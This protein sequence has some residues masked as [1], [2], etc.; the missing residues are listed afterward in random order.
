MLDRDGSLDL[1]RSLGCFSPAWALFSFLTCSHLT[2]GWTGSSVF[3][4]GAT[5]LPAR[6]SIDPS[7]TASSGSSGVVMLN[8]SS[9]RERMVEAQIARRGIRD[10]HVLQAMRRVPREAFV[11]PGFDEFA[12]ED[13]PLP[14]GEDQTIS[15]PYIVA[16]MIEA[17]E[18][19]PGE[20]V[21]E[22]GAGSGYSAAV[23][24]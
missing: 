18:V 20:R 23:L 21:L 10:R 11:E 17:A 5:Q 7:A 15:Q 12:Y 4:C 16:A 1:R 22:V 19:K 2:R 9:A 3:R 8:P 14:I 24:S 13:S 6:K